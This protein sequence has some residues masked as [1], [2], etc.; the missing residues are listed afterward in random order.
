MSTRCFSVAVAVVIMVHSLERQH[1]LPFIRFL[2]ASPPPLKSLSPSMFSKVVGA[3]DSAAIAAVRHQAPSMWLLCPGVG[4]QGGDL[5]ACCAAGLFVPSENSEPTGTGSASGS[6]KKSRRATGLLFPVSRGL[7][8]APDPAVAARDLKESINAARAMIEA[9]AEEE[10][11][12]ARSSE[13]GSAKRHK[14]NNGAA[15]ALELAPYQQEFVQFATANSI[16]KFGSFTLKSGRVSPYFFN[17]GGVCTG[18]G[19]A[20]LAGF[21]AQALVAPPALPFDVLFGPAYKGIPL[22]TAVGVALYDLGVDV[23]VCYNRKEAKDHGEG[24]L[25]VGAELKVGVE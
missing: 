13:E 1:S 4:A 3:T 20:Q 22:A 15:D 11:A 9:K 18:G 2:Q 24:G 19:I 14:G 23:G 16:L 21:Y 6:A 10:E 25:L 12:T 8:N 5:A 7:S 17:A